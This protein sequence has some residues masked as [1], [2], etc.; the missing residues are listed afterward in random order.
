MAHPGF[1]PFLKPNDDFPRKLQKSYIEYYPEG[2]LRE[3]VHVLPAS[4]TYAF[5]NGTVSISKP[6]FYMMSAIP[7]SP[8]T[9]RMH[10]EIYRNNTA[11][12][13]RRNSTKPSSSSSRSNARTLCSGTAHS[14]ISIVIRMTKTTATQ[15]RSYIAALV[16]V[17]P[18]SGQFPC[19]H[20]L[21]IFYSPT[22]YK[23]QTRLT[24]GCSSVYITV[25]DSVYSVHIAT[26]LI[27]RR[28]TNHA[29]CSV[30]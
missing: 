6:F 12:P 26:L 14:A 30:V 15:V 24:R 9:T 21:Y 11:P 27:S 10:Y 23:Q 16:Q 13:L 20:I 8:T 19:H 4:P 17:K 22:R 2:S 5:P 25:I 1:A 3:D 28:S 29:S 7:T 18:W